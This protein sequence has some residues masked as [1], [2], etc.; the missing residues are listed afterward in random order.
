MTHSDNSEDYSE[1]RNSRRLNLDYLLRLEHPSGRELK[2]LSI[3]ISLGGLRV[4]CQDEPDDS[5]LGENVNLILADEKL[6]D[7]IFECRVN[8]LENKLMAL[9]LERRSATRFGLAISK[10]MFK[11]TG[12]N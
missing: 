6:P 11:H 4:A 5:W 7:E 3:D 12:T 2:G 1:K 9:E 10:N 8:R